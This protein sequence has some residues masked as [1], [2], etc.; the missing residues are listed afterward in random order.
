VCVSSRRARASVTTGVGSLT[1]WPGI[2]FGAVATSATAAEKS[3]RTPSPFLPAMRGGPPLKRRLA[4]ENG[5]AR[6]HW[7]F[8]TGAPPP[9]VVNLRVW[10]TTR[11]TFSIFRSFRTNNCGRILQIRAE[12]ATRLCELE[13]FGKWPK[14]KSPV[15]RRTNKSDYFATRDGNSTLRENSSR[16]KPR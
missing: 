4:H 8:R 5:S 3:K 1:S 6:R 14:P 15:G 10:K 13:S 11:E 16:S 12:A 9:G 7:A 2:V